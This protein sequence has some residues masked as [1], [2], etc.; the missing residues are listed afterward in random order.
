MD[1]IR[2][3][4]VSGTSRCCLPS[5]IPLSKGLYL[6][7]MQDRSIHQWYVLPGA[8]YFHL[9]I[10]PNR[11]DHT[12]E[13]HDA[14]ASC[15]LKQSSVTVFLSEPLVFIHIFLNSERSF[16]TILYANATLVCI[17]PIYIYVGFQFNVLAR[18]I[19]RY[20]LGVTS[21]LAV[22]L[23]PGGETHAYNYAKESHRGLF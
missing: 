20:V 14:T 2:N 19:T 13:E 16:S 23:W 9:F 6:R 5:L 11:S 15:K 1:P 10:Y 7:C 3:Y 17:L 18:S 21:P 8:Q 4:M 12:H 22:S